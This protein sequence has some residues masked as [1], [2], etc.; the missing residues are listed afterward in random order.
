MHAAP[1]SELAVAH[2]MSP[3]VVEL[4]HEMPIIPSTCGRARRHAVSSTARETALI[5]LAFVPCS[6]RGKIS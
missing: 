6:E 1:V 3:A 5:F 2:T 4:T